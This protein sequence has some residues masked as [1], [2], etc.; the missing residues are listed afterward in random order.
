MTAGPARCG[1]HRSPWRLLLCSSRGSHG[2][3]IGEGTPTPSACT[4]HRSAAA[5][6]PAAPHA[7][8][9]KSAN[10]TGG[11]ADVRAPRGTQ[12][13][14]RRPD[15]PRFASLPRPRVPPWGSRAQPTVGS[16][17][18]KA[19]FGARGGAPR[20]CAHP[21]ST[22]TDPEG[23]SAALRDGWATRP[24]GS[25]GLNASVTVAPYLTHTPSTLT[26]AH[27]HTRTAG[28]AHVTHP[29]RR[30]FLPRPPHYSPQRAPRRACAFAASACG[31]EV[32]APPGAAPGAPY[33]RGAEPCRAVP[34]AAPSCGC[35]DSVTVGSCYP[36]GLLGACGRW[37][38]QVWGL[39]AVET[40]RR[41]VR[42][43]RVGGGSAPRGFVWGPGLRGGP[44]RL[45]SVAVSAVSTCRFP[46]SSM[47]K[48]SSRCQ[49]LCPSREIPV[50]S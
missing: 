26:T 33:V 9:H 28:R 32:A 13:T 31:R 8:P 21:P 42:R 17:A 2:T 16:G 47:L 50:G 6:P 14:L 3:T 29:N 46:V 12:P 4:A 20:L 1:S 39:S 35:G 36:P 41:L 18:G 10:T 30:L 49:P 22:G 23:R 45:G 27:T 44:G 5:A 15:C 37:G 43:W 48:P 11:F 38:R 34:G 19:P 24:W 25:S 40:R 7:V